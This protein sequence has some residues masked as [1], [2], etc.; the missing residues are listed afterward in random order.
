MCQVNAIQSNPFLVTLVSPLFRHR[1]HVW[2]DTINVINPTQDP[3]FLKLLDYHPF[4][5]P[6]IAVG[7]RI[8]YSLQRSYHLSP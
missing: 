2:G 5:F 1:L 3:I 6:Y 7:P 4:H 8:L